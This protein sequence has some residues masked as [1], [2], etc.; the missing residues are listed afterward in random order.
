VRDE[1]GAFSSAATNPEMLVSNGRP[2]GSLGHTPLTVVQHGQPIYSQALPEYGARLQRIWTTGQRE[3][4]AL[5]RH[6]RLVT[7]KKSGHY[8]YL[9]QQALTVQLI[10]HATNG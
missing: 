2:L 9:D 1:V 10:Q 6:S 8:I 4:A 3:L 7:A 5:S